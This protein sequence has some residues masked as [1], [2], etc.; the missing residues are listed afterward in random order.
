V[1]E[2]L[3]GVDG[4]ESSHRALAWALDEAR[5][6]G[7]VVVVVHA[8]R[9]PN[10][11]NPYAIGY[12]YLPAD[13]VRVATEQERRLQ[14]EQET[15]VRQQAEGI[16]QQALNEARH[17]IDDVTVKRLTLARDPAKTLVEM[18]EHAELLVVGSRGLG[19]FRGLLLGSVSQQCVHHARCPVV[20]IR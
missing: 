5:L 3:I 12:P 9:R 20:V 14:D 11:R 17:H 6:R 8:Y 4:S 19:G 15:H 1:G 18:S 7:D 13:T 2:I 16:I 10:V